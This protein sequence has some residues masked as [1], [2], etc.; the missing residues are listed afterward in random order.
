MKRSLK[1]SRPPTT[2]SLVNRRRKTTICLVRETGR[3][4]THLVASSMALMRT[5]ITIE[6]GQI[7]SR[8]S[9]RVGRRLR[10]TTANTITSMRTS[11]TPTLRKRRSTIVKSLGKRQATI[12]SSKIPGSASPRQGTLRTLSS[13]SKLLV[14]AHQLSLCSSSRFSP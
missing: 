12:G 5:H 2:S 10:R 9:T 4:K 7:P 13:T 14:Q 3:L 1:R 6:R 11:A 8:T